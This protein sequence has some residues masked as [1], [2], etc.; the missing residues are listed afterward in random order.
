LATFIFKLPSSQ[1]PLKQLIALYDPIID[2]FVQ[3]CDVSSV[4]LS[5]HCSAKLSPHCLVGLE[6]KSTVCVLLVLELAVKMISLKV[7]Y[8]A[9]ARIA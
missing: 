7:I 5:Q 2:C 6:K 4:H 9:V 8:Y 1:K 3:Y